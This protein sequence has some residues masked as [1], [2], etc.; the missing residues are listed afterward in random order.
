MVQQEKL[1]LEFGVYV[2]QVRDGK[3]NGEGQMIFKEDDVIVR[4]NKTW[5]KR[6][7]IVKFGLQ[8]KL[9]NLHVLESIKK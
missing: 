8:G 1:H 5:I 6:I 4:Y 9:W 2:G 3:P 7:F